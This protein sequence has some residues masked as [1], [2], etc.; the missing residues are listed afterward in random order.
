MRYFSYNE[1]DPDHPDGGYVVTVSEED[2]RRDYYEFWYGEM[3]KKFGKDEV[4]A[5]YCF[6]DC[7]DDFCIVNWAWEVKDDTIEN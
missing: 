4:D 3:C 1:Y 7:I 5:K 6:E 2:I